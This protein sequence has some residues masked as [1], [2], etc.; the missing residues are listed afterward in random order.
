[1][2]YKTI[3]SNKFNLFWTTALFLYTGYVTGFYPFFCFRRKCLVPLRDDPT[4][5]QSEANLPPSN[6]LQSSHSG[7][8]VIKLFTPL[9]R[10]Y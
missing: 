6:P 5:N 7:P 10:E 2:L 1:M 9:T 8:N 3:F 4:I